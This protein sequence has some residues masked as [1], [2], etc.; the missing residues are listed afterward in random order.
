MDLEERKKMTN[1]MYVIS[2]V[3]AFVGLVAF[4]SLVKVVLD[5]FRFRKRG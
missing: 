5:S 1:F 2:V 3:L 4:V